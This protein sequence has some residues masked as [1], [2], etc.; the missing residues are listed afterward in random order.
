[1][2]RYADVLLLQAEAL[3]EQGRTADAVAL[4]NQVRQRP[5][6]NLAP[7]GSFTQAGL[8]TRLM[9]E[10]A[11][12]LA[13]EGV[14]WLDLQ[15]WGL[16]DN[17]TGVDELKTHD[18]QFNTFVVGKSRLLPILQTEIDLLKLTQNSGY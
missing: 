13:G 2:I 16:L 1:V 5:S 4:I 11:T 12:E 14:R 7:L 18:A 9:H 8:R 17:Q 15:R 6:V 3:N 10:R